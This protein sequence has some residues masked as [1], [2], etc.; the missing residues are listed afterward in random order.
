MTRDDRRSVAFFCVVDGPAYLPMA[1][2]ALQSFGGFHPSADCFVVGRFGDDAH[3]MAEID[4]HGLGFLQLDL[5]EVFAG[6]IFTPDH[7]KVTWPSECFW[8][9]SC[10]RLFA[11]VGYRFSC[12]VDGDTLCVAP[13]AVE[14]LVGGREAVAGVA[15]RNGRVNSGVL[16][17][18]NDRLADLPEQAQHV[19]R[20]AKSCDHVGCT[21]FCQARGDQ[22]LLWELEQRCGLMVRR[23]DNAFNHMLTWS[24]D[25]YREGNPDAPMSVA[26]SVVLHLLSKP[27]RRPPRIARVNPVMADGYSRWWRHT[28]AVWPN[29]AERESHFGREYA[30]GPG[31]SV[32]RLVGKPLGS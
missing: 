5:R 12:A 25:A 24:E 1:I 32:R 26:D 9:T 29:R 8:W 27:W 16:C 11:E 17:F 10:P 20:T 28:R 14:G 23:I 15:K 31:R 2:T 18:D 21:G 7:P 3:A 6:T 4:R 13:I 22:G 19:Y 30:A